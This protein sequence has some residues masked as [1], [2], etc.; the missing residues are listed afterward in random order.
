MAQLE[1][2]FVAPGLGQVPHANALEFLGCGAVVL[3]LVVVVRQFPLRFQRQGALGE[4]SNE[5]FYPMHRIPVVQG[6]RAHGGVV[7][8]SA[9]ASLVV[10]DASD[11]N[12]SN[13]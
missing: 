9:Y 6:E 2:V 3:S 12:S 13:V 8:P 7:G 4:L 1:A 10:L 5:R 11:I